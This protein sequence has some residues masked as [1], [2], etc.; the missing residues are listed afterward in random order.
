MELKG[1]RTEKNLKDA[2]AGESQANRRYLYF[3]NKADVEGQ[4]DIAALQVIVEE[5]GGA[6][7]D[8]QGRPFR[9]NCRD[10]LRNGD[11]IVAGADAVYFGLEDFNA[12]RRAAN[13]TLAG[14][15]Q[16]RETKKK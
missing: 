8:T 9:Y 14:L 15:P 2:F 16:F 10:S 1:S 5:A 3:A 6:L 13:F 7:L 4:Q 11:F 12:R